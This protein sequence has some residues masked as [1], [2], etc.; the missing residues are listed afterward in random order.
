[1]YMKNTVNILNQRIL[2]III[3]IVSMTWSHP[4]TMLWEDRLSTITI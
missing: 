4:I 3:I 1:M 2:L